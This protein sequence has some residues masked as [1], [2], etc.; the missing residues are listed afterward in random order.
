MNIPRGYL[1]SENP[2][3]MALAE[4][5]QAQW[6]DAMI[7]GK[8]PVLGHGVKFISLES[9]LDPAVVICGHCGQWGAVQTECRH[10]GASI[11]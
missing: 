1:Q 7:K 2:I 10:C 11:F 6:Q 3:P 5:I 8:T 9:A 4:H